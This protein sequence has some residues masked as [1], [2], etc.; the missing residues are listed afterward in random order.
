MTTIFIQARMSSSRLPKKVLLDLAGKPVLQWVVDRCKQVK[1]ANGII[2]LTS[3]DPD[4]DVIEKY[5]QSNDIDC[6]RG[7]LEDVLSRYY[8]AAIH[9][10]VNSFVRITADCPFVDPTIIDIVIMH[11]I[12]N[13]YEYTGL[14]G[15]FPDGLDCEFFSKRAI[16]EA[17]FKASKQYQ[18]EHIGQY[19]AENNS[20]FI[21]GKVEL[22]NH[23]QGLRLTLDEPADYKFL[24]KIAHL[25]DS[26]N[27]SILDIYEV[28]RRFPG[29]KKINAGIVRNEGLI[30]SK[31]NEV[32]FR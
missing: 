24:K 15:N 10:N 13:K 16:S 8:L 19:I 1:Y 7:P 12:V 29:L 27:F 28:M 14:A 20:D 31:E 21:C 5:C 4:D 26:S 9:Y 3:T 22:F 2:V 32:E 17:Y 25:L 23:D 30:K 6:F 11:G 18:R